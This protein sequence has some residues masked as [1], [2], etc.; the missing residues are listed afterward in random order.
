MKKINIL[1]IILSIIAL[2]SIIALVTIFIITLPNSISKYLILFYLI[3]LE[4]LIFSMQI[5]SIVEIRNLDN[6]EHEKT[7]AYFKDNSWQSYIYHIIITIPLMV[8][9]IIAVFAKITHKNV[10]PEVILQFIYW[11]IAIGNFIWFYWHLKKADS[12]NKIK[13]LNLML[14]LAVCIVSGVGFMMDVI[15]KVNFTRQFITMAWTFLLMSYIVDKKI[16]QI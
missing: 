5:S 2:C 16:L 9:V 3:A 8:M 15:S 13:K 10:M 4:F 14:K 6:N 7:F 1:Q 12:L 11:S